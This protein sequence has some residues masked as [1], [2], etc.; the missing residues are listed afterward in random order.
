[1]VADGIVLPVGGAT[2]TEDGIQR[3]I[4][5]LVYLDYNA[6]TPVLPEVREA[7]WPYLNDAWGNPS[8]AYRFGAEAMGAIDRAREQ[9]A[10]LIGAQFEEITFSSCATEANN[11]AIHSALLT[12]E[13][14]RHIVTSEVEHSSV[15]HYCE[16]LARRGYPVTFLRVDRDGLI[17]LA[18][19][20]AAIRQDTAIVSLMWANN[21]TGVI[22]PVQAIGELCRKREV[23]YHCDAVQAVG[24]LPLDFASLPI[25]F[26]TL[27]GHKL[28]APKGVGALVVRHGTRF[29]PLIVGG[30]QEA[31]RRGGTES[32]SLIVALG[33]ASEQ[34]NLR[35]ADAWT[36]IAAMRD[37]LEQVLLSSIPNAYRNGG[38]LRL[39]NTLNFGV[40]GLD[41]SALVA[42]LDAQGI[43]VSAGSACME[44]AQAPSHVIL[45]MTRNHQQATE[46]VRISLGHESR[47][48]EI[49]AA[50]VILTNAA[51]TLR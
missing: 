44:S 30:M 28:G 19:L 26:L 31:G 37:E 34:A 13:G 48:N 42:Y 2:L 8:S 29:E 22:S 50:S 16:T 47:L 49:L 32:V 24:K 9:V 38:S 4:G 36:K 21:E 23:C 33:A 51:K 5:L 10:K 41:G 1:V 40:P 14:K 15:L 7:M 3:I 11:T 43:C 35:S 20:E 39:P 46:S 45:A 27:S 12:N 6:T 18:D 17:D 25:D